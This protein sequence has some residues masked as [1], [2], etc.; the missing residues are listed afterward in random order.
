MTASLTTPTSL[1]AYFGFPIFCFSKGSCFTLLC[2]I[3]VPLHQDH[4]LNIFEHYAH[5][6][7]KQACPRHFLHCTLAIWTFTF[8]EKSSCVVNLEGQFKTTLQVIILNFL[9]WKFR[10]I[11]FIFL[12]FFAGIAKSTAFCTLSLLKIFELWFDTKTLFQYFK[13]FGIAATCEKSIGFDNS[14]KK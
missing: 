5:R 13:I 2:T 14:C 1:H 7:L 3:N 6:L 9:I 11:I 10:P 12:L 8:H 4:I